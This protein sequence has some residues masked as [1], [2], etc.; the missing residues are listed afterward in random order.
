MACGMLPRAVIA[1]VMEWRRSSLD[2]WLALTYWKICPVLWAVPRSSCEPVAADSFAAPRLSPPQRLAKEQHPVYRQPSVRCRQSCPPDPA[3]LTEV[4]V[5]KGNRI[6]TSYRRSA[7][8]SYC[9]V[10]VSPETCVIARTAAS[11][12]K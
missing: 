6:A 3:I 7:A 5:G 4:P 12:A 1:D 8:R 10:G 9:R 11:A 2:Q